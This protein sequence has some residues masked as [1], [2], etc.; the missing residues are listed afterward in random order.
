MT[1]HWIWRLN[2]T[3]LDVQFQYF[4]QEGRLRYLAFMMHFF[5]C[6]VYVM[7]YVSHD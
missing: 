3:S 5:C 4:E 6:I 7:F 1:H 2:D